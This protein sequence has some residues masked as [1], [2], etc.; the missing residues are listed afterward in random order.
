RPQIATVDRIAS[1]IIGGV[2]VALG[3]FTGHA[4]V[5]T[6]IDDGQ[7]YHPFEA[8]VLIVANIGTSHH[9]KLVCRFSRDEIDHACSRI[10]AIERTLRT[11]ENFRLAQIEK[12]LL[13][14]VVP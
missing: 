4:Q 12:F 11:A 5:E 9:F 14:E 6:V 3:P 8:A 7:I 13:E 10:A 2:A 1:K